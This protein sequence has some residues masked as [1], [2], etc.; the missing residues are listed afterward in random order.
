MSDGPLSVAVNGA[1]GFVGVHVVRELTDRGH[2]AVALVRE[3]SNPADLAVLDSVA[4]R[5]V[6]VDLDREDALAEAMQ[7]CD[8]LV[9]LI[10]SIAPKKGTRFEDMHGGMASRFFGAAKTAG[11]AKAAIITALGAGPEAGSRYHRT[12]WQSEQ[13]LRGSGLEY[14]VLRPSLIV[15]RVVGHRDSKMV[16]RYVDLIEHKKKVPLIFGGKNLVQPIFVGD[17]A[18]A[19]CDVLEKPDWD[20]ATL[21]LGGDE[22]MTTRQLIGRLMDAVDVQKGCVTVP[23]PLAWCAATVMETVQEIPLLSRDQLRIARIDGNCQRN[24]LV[25]DLG[26]TPAPLKEV[27]LAY[28]QRGERSNG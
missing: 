5:T 12:K 15:G 10:G 11:V 1:T 17:L 2:T 20:G 6:C 24:A 18:K 27:L 25:E 7:G 9:H 23:G 4:A 8:R 28:R 22:V 21:D 14:V 19:V 3:R 16:R 26:L 13:A